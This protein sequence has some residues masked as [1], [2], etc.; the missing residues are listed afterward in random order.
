VLPAGLPRGLAAALAA[1][2][3]PVRALESAGGDVA[4]VR[5]GDPGDGSEA[6]V[7]AALHAPGAAAAVLDDAA[8]QIGG[9]ADPPGRAGMLA[10]L[11]AAAALP[12]TPG[13]NHAIVALAE[14]DTDRDPPLEAPVRAFLATPGAIL[15]VIEPRGDAPHVADRPLLGPEPPP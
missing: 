9:G 10:G 7:V 1:A 15:I 8:A 13:R 5:V 4:V 11:A 3:A 12:W 14:D 6:V 2:A